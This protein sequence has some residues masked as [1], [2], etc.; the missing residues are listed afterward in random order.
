[1]QVSDTMARWGPGPIADSRL[2]TA[3]YLLRIA[4]CQ[5]PIADP[6]LRITYCGLPIGLDGCEQQTR[7][8]ARKAL[9]GP[10]DFGRVMSP[11]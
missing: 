3:D 11:D 5:R 2:P 1:V 4:D 8:A 10:T 9:T 7:L 6:R